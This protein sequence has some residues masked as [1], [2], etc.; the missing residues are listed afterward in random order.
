MLRGQCRFHG[1]GSR[2]LC[3]PTQ[4]QH[5]SDQGA[6]LALRRAAPVNPT[7]TG[8]ARTREGLVTFTRLFSLPGTVCPGHSMSVISLQ[9]YMNGNGLCVHQ[10]A[11]QRESKSLAISSVILGR[12]RAPDLC[13]LCGLDGRGRPEPG[14]RRKSLHSRRAQ[15]PIIL[16][17]SGKP[18]HDS[19]PHM[20]C[21]VG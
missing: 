19:A 14:G 15:S 7:G 12:P 8:M 4:G 10:G 3:S 1:Q 5:C 21:G 2:R 9:C 16:D 17:H 6:R 13:G 18:S 20:D 11:R